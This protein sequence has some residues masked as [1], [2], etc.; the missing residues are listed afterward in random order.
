MLNTD[1]IVL[2]KLD[3]FVDMSSSPLASQYGGCAKLLLRR[4]YGRPEGFKFNGDFCGDVELLVH[5]GIAV[6]RG[7]VL[8]LNKEHAVVSQLS[9]V[10]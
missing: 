7:G 8:I 6:K 10:K 9:S 4:L 5:E 3:E 2:K 1:V